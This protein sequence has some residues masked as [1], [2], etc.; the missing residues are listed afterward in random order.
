VRKRIERRMGFILLAAMIC[1]LSVGG[2]QAQ[3]YP[4]GPVQIIIPFGPGGLMDIF[5]RGVS[6][7]VGFSLKGTIVLVNKTGGGGVVGTAFAAVARPDGYTIVSA[8]SDPPNISPVFTPNVT[9]NP[10]SYTNELS[11]QKIHCTIP[12][13]HE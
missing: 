10:K 11:Y 6:E 3:D 5:W 13:T 9:Y 7:F 1:L 12:M 4:K 8:N 2:S